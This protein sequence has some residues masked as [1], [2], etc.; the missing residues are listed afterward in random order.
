MTEPQRKTS[1]KQDPDAVRQDILSVAI[2][3]FGEHGLSGARVDEIAR[4]TRTSKRM[5][6]YYFVD[7]EG[8][9]QNA[10]Q[11]E[12]DRLRDDR[13]ALKLDALPPIEA[14]RKLTE[15]MFDWH[16]VNLDF[17][18]MVVIENALGARHLRQS[19]TMDGRGAAVT[20]PL[21]DLLTR[22]VDEG[23][24]RTGVDPVILH[25]TMT[26]VSF[27]NTSNRHTFP[28]IFGEEV[29][30]D[31]QQGALRDALVRMVFGLVLKPKAFAKTV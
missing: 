19:K 29:R 18:R 5:I 31:A 3:E 22:G 15:F 17:V 30:S 26:G 9:Y 11:R 27:Y 24:F 13:A 20:G 10:L 8:L 7:K 28:L 2:R 16:R 23:V 21:Q 25:M 14:L 4:K 12:Y 6:Y 1:W